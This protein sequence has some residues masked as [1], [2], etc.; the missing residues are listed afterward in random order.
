[1]AR[2]APH[3]SRFGIVASRFNREI[4]DRLVEGALGF[5]RE[6][7]VPAAHVDVVRVPGA[8]EL[9]MAALRLAR[10]GRYRAVVALGCILKGETPQY[11]YLSQATL[12]G[13]ML[14]GVLTGVPVTSGVVTAQSW[15]MAKA[16]SAG[17]LNRGR[18]AAEAAW[19]MAR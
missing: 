3:G 12:Q 13:L 2:R 11:A 9:P 5:F 17:R 1:M 14:A 10:S 4:T 18:E 16:R 6:R 8:F 19:E 15:S 7:K